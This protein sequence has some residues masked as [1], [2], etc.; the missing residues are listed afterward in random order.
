M[1]WTD[2]LNGDALS[3]LLEPDTSG[4]RYLALLHL[5]D[6][7]QDSHELL[8]ARRQAHTQGPIAALLKAMHP[9]GYWVEPGAGYYPKYTGTVWSLITLAMLGATLAEDERVSRAGAYL[10]DHALTPAGQRSEERRV[11]K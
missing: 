8:T 10:L 2:Q 4:V 9:D 3:W 1:A 5:L 11:G 6:V 7:H